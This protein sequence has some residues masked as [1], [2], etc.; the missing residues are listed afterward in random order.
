[1]AT[2]PTNDLLVWANTD[3]NLPNLAGPNKTK[4]SADLVAKGWDF[5]QKPSADEFNYILNNL[6]MHISY[7]EESFTYTFSGDVT[8]EVSSSGS[9]DISI[10]L[11]VVDNSHNHTSAN[12]SD[13]TS[14]NNPNTIVKRGAT[15]KISVGDITVN[16]TSGVSEITFSA[17]SNDPG[18]IKHSETADVAKMQFSISDNN[19]TSDAFE[20]GNTQGGTFVPKLT[21]KGNGTLET[22][23]D[24]TAPNFHGNLQGNADTASKWLTSRTITLAGDLTGSVDLD[25][26]SNVTLTAQVIDDSHNHVIAN[27]D[28][29]TEALAGKQSVAVLSGIIS[30]GGTIP[31]PSGYSEGQCSWMVSID[32]SNSNGAGWDIDNGIVANHISHRCYTTG[33]VV[34]A[35]TTVRDEAGF[36]TYDATANYIIIGVK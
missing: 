19:D 29:L 18:F 24:I 35:N 11:Q 7:L 36:R 17:T 33:R 2:R 27:V 16:K 4:P 13:A 21:I 12:I 34:T 9:E 10:N 3:V 15:G 6:G 5:K 8:G 22:V 28:G 30:N 1:M 23:A 14:A 32:N 20:F 31:L 25:G 26:A